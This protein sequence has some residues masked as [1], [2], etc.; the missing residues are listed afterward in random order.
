MIPWEGVGDTWGGGCAKFYK[1][2]FEE[3]FF[4]KTIWSEEICVES[5]ADS[6]DLKFVQIVVPGGR[7]G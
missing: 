3:I 5:S 2:I 6:K 1:T 7:V 4:S